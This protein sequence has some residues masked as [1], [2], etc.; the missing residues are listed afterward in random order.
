[1][2]E[3]SLRALVV[4]VSDFGEYDKIL[5]LLSEEK[6]IVSVSVKGGKSL[7]SKFS[8]LSEMFS[9]G[10]FN[11]RRTGKYYY[12]FDGELVE[13]F[14]ALR[15]DIVKLSLASYF[16]EVATALSPEGVADAELLK[17]TLNALYAVCYMDT[18]KELVKG[19]FEFKAS[20][21]AGYMPELERC[22]V[23]GRD[24]ADMM[25][26]D[27]RNG[28]I[29]CDRCLGLDS[30]VNGLDSV[31]ILLPVPEGVLAAF[32]YLS[33]CPVKKFLSFRLADSEMRDFEITSEKYLINHMEREFYTL[34]FYKSVL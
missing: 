17:L 33:E 32:R 26:I 8:A 29:L 31:S 1:M 13:D 34:D 6:G 4:R 11:V 19:A 3:L 27:T 14:Y 2:D 22:A 12:L 25:Y 24:T 9:Y 5:T 10:V 16:C 30:E 20:V 15:S 28:R 21:L 7:K 23:C 18:P